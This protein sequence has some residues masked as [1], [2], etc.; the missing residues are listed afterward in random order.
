MPPASIAS[1]LKTLELM[2]KEPWRRERLWEI[3]KRMQKEFKSM[4]FNIGA[5]ATPIIPI[6]VGE[7]MACFQF[8]KHLTEEGL[9]TNPIISPAVPKGQAL[10]RTSYSANLTDKQLDRVLDI[11]QR[12]GKKFGLI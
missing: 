9:F 2:Q 5:T 12:V 6:Y 1:C 8:W 3:T 7:D 11:F 10:I 4:G